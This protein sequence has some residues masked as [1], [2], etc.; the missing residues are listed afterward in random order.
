MHRVCVLV[1]LVGLV[2]LTYVLY[3]V[4][5]VQPRVMLALASV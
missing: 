1:L 4:G 3:M 5:H 2:A